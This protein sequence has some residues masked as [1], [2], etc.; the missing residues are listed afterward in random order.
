MTRDKICTLF[1][2]NFEASVCD[3]TKGRHL[4]A[5]G[6]VKKMCGG[7]R[8]KVSVFGYRTIVT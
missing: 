3:L 1:G 2:E 4:G 7:A 8:R 5:V 6:E